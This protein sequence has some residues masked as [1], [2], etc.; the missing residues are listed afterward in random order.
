MNSRRPTGGARDMPHVTISRR[1]LLATSGLAAIGG[2]SGC[3][4]RVASR[5]TNT[6]ASP[7]AVFAGVDRNDDDAVGAFGFETTDG[8]P[9][10]SRLTPT[11][12]GGSG[13]L[14]GEVEL[15]G[16]VTSSAVLAQDYNSSRSNKP[17]T[18][19]TDADSDGDGLS[20]ADEAD[21]VLAYLGGNPVVAER[22]AVCLPDAEVP[23]GN[24][25][26]REAVTPR[27]FIE[28]MTGKSDG[29][30]RVYSWGTPKAGPGDPD[31]STDCDDDDPDV[32][33]G[34]VCGTTPHFVA[35]VTG[36]TATGGSLAVARADDGTVVVTNSPPEADGGPAAVRVDAD[37]GADGPESSTEAIYQ[38]W[39]SGSSNGS[40]K[41][42]PGVHET[43]VAQVLVRPPGCP[44]PFPALFYVGRGR[45]DDQ[46]VYT[47]GWVV[48]DAA[49]YE[50]S[51]TVLSLAGPT[52][53]VGIECCFDYSAD[54]DGDGF[55]DAVARAGLSER[56]RRGARIASGTVDELVEA[57]VLS[58]SGG[59]DILIRKRPGRGED[60]ESRLVVTGD[61]YGFV[62]NVPVDAPVLHLMNAG[63]A[64]DEVKFKAGAELSK[65]VN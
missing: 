23:G 34:A 7:A 46:L 18:R 14:S 38:A 65:S 62:T 22:F 40:G 2:L 35:D 24:G 1:R 21:E 63:D 61:E 19:S 13:V 11:V 5:V 32:F 54:A 27:R 25:S 48:D 64:P 28:Y 9:H 47:G 58:E 60:G 29:G 8:A 42:T 10:V 51:A 44:H 15:E 39:S 45:S 33:P 16:W 12:A 56:A 3:L 31:T 26:I 53:V 6:G 59:N 36:P 52:Q 4:S 43:L 41:A 30:G 20:D 57:G 55:S 49:L 50:R 37:G 17:R